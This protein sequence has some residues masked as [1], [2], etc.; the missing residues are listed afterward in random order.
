M[1]SMNTKHGHGVGKGFVVGR[2]ESP[3]SKTAQILAGEKTKAPSVSKYS[4]T[5]LLLRGPDGLAGILYDIDRVP[6]C[7]LVDRRHIRTLSK[8]MHRNN[9]FCA[10]GDRS[11]KQ[12]RIDIKRIRLNVDK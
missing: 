4:G 10:R 12:C 1:T 11:F 3:I 7:N 5:P 6:F 2:D 8:E 9:G